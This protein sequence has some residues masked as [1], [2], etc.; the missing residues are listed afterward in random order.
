MNKNELQVLK[1]ELSEVI[2]PRYLGKHN[3]KATRKEIGYD[4][5]KFLTEKKYDFTTINTHTPTKLVDEQKVKLEVDDY[6][7]IVSAINVK[8]VE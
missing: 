2:I 5:M 4:V 3:D 6:V 1:Q 8:E 7:L